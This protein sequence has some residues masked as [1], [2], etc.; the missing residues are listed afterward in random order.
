M[1]DYIPVVPLVLFVVVLI[2]V[3]HFIRLMHAALLHMTLRK[4]IADKDPV[5]RDL[6]EK[7]DQRLDQPGE[8]QGDDRNGLVLVAIGLA[9]FGFGLIQQNAYLR[10]T[11]GAALFPALVGAALLLRDWQVRRAIARERSAG[12]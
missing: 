1:P 9:I 4:A 12:A 6:A 7:I 8:L 11:L 2:G 5:A 10:P 3:I